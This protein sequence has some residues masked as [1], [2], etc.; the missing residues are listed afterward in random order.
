MA[1]GYK[2]WVRKGKDVY[3]SKRTF[4]SIKRARELMV[5]TADRLEA[6]CGNVVTQVILTKEA[7]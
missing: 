2:F 7:R 3:V 1:Y 5:R 6:V 4:R